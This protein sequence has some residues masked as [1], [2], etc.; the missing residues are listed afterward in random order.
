MQGVFITLEG[1]EGAGKSTVIQGLRA[2]LEAEGRRVVVTR[3]PGAG[4]FGQ[5]VRQ[6]L[7]HSE[8]M[9]P[10][11]ELFLFLA[12][13]ANHVATVIRPALAEGAVV[14]CDRFSDSTVV[15][16]GYARGLDL[17]L[18]RSLN[19]T[20]TGGLKPDLTLL[21]DV[22][23]EVGLARVTERDRLDSESLEFHVRV[24]DGFLAEM[25]R[26]PAR[27]ARVDASRKASEV[28]AECVGAVMARLQ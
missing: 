2:A 27:W 21:L 13:R 5:Q 23:P 6:I 8:A 20:A 28:L 3:E 16:Q 9:P 15:Y 26:E 22:P 1:P 11:A 24:R 25:K 14:L 12:D 4:A 19:E 7:L 18:L 17:D 10:M